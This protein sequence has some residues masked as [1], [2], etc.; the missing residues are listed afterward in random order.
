MIRN[1]AIRSKTADNYAWKNGS[2]E[3]ASNRHGR[4]TGKT[5]NPA[6]FGRNNERMNTALVTDQEQWIIE[7]VQYLISLREIVLMEGQPLAGRTVV[8]KLEIRLMVVAQVYANTN[9]EIVGN[10][11]KQDYVESD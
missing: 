1:G 3:F 6:A 11:N 7:D 10:K 5:R 8:V 2:E 4:C 9:S